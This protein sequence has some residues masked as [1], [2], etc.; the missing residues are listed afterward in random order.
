MPAILRAGGFVVRVHGPP[1]EHPP[2]HV[3]VERGTDQLVVIRLG[4]ATTPPRV[5]AVYRMS[6]QDVVRAFR[7]VE[8][9]HALI[10]SAWRSIHG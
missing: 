8:Q 10:E 1:R 9:H 5:W 4:T 6:N 7:L 3:H 2:P